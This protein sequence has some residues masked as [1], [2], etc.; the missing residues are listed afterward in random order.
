MHRLLVV[1]D[2]SLIADGLYEVFR[3]LARLDLDVYKAYSAAEALEI[4]HQTRMDIV[5]TDIHMP[6]MSGLE[7]LGEIK[8]R[9]PNCLVII[10]TG[11]DKF[12]Y[13]YEAIQY[14]GVSYLL[15]TEDYDAVIGAVEKAAAEIEGRAARETLI[16]AANER[17]EKAKDLMRES[18]L[19]GM[20]R[21]RLGE[22]DIGSEQFL[23]MDV[24]LRARDKVLLLVARVERMPRALSHAEK[25]RRL[26]GVRHIAAGFLRPKV[27]YACAAEG[28][29]LLLW[30]IQ[31]PEGGDWGECATFARGGAELIQATALD[32]L[33]V[34]LSFALDEGPADWLDLPDRL[35]N[36]E[37]GLSFRVDE[38]AG[39]L[40]SSRTEDRA[41]AGAAGSQASAAPGARPRAPSPTSTRLSLER[42]AECLEQGDAEG[43]SSCFEALAAPLAAA[44]VAR[45]LGATESYYAIALVLL[46][47]INRRGLA[48]GVSSRI[49]LHKLTCAEAHATWADAVAYLRELG[50]VLFAA[51]EVDRESRA[52]DAVGRIKR[53]VVDHILEPDELTLVRLAEIIDL[54][55]SY[56]SRVFKKLADVNLS[57]FIAEARIKKAKSLLEDRDMKVQ[58]VGEALGY[59]TATNFTRFFKKLAGLTPQEYRDRDVKS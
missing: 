21:G 29:S 6:G 35:A 18:Y 42:M 13:V 12:E 57:D 9:W 17:M 39:M 8:G 33:G 25:F 19:V 5:L 45:D 15:K 52:Q 43:Y 37:L 20:A 59:G 58:E 3:G 53:H 40:L 38:E 56:L 1:D 41:D 30:F 28:S 11:Y 7:L 44:G 36:L 24:P 14:P 31:R 34:A 22:S 54:N 4:L 23:E 2:E 55:P 10:L 49:G 50:G 47:F 32:S 27:D 48:E 26:Y 46:S 51:M 16:E